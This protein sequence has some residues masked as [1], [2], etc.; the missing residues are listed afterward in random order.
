[1]FRNNRLLCKKFKMAKDSVAKML[2]VLAP[3]VLGHFVLRRCPPQDQDEPHRPYTNEIASIMWPIILVFM[4]F[5]WQF[6]R[7]AAGKRGAQVDGAFLLAVASLMGWFYFNF[8]KHSEPKAMLMLLAAAV[9]GTAVTFLSGRHDPVSSLLLMPYLVWLLLAER[10]KIPKI[11]IRLPSIK[12][13]L[14]SVTITRNGNGAATP[15]PSSTGASAAVP[16]GPGNGGA[17]LTVAKANGDSAVV[18]TAPAPPSRSPGAPAPAG[19][20]GPSDAESPAPTA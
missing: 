7:A 5:A 15:P 4:G 19:E 8:C 18:A 10:W 3:V 11:R 9:S 2:R 13:R 14:P 1:M 20:K 12:V 16:P 6:A 17:L